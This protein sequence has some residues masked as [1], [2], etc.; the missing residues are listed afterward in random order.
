LQRLLP[1]LLRL[2][3]RRRPR[4][5]LPGQGRPCSGLAPISI[6]REIVLL[7]T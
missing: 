5:L 6:Q 2:L 7:S 3:H 1:R 4:R